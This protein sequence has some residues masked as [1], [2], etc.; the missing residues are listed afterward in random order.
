MDKPVYDGAGHFLIIEN[1]IPMTEFKV[2]SNNN[3]TF[4]I[5]LWDNLK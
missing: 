2:G 5:T 1:T 3:T 4:F